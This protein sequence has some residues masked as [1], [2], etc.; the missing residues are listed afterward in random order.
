MRASG[1]ATGSWVMRNVAA[2]FLHLLD[3]GQSPQDLA[4]AYVAVRREIEA[5]GHGLEHKYEVLVLNKSDLMSPGDTERKRRAVA[6]VSGVSAMMMSGEQGDNVENVLRALAAALAQWRSEH[7]PTVVADTEAVRAQERIAR[8]RKGFRPSGAGRRER[9]AHLRSYPRRQNRFFN[10]G[11]CGVGCAGARLAFRVR[12]RRGAGESARAG[13]RARVVGRDC[14]WA[15]ARFELG[16]GALKLEEAQAAAAVGQI[17][18]AR[19]WSEALA[20]HQADGRAGVADLGRYG[21]PAA[22][23]QRAVDAQDVDRVG[24]RAG[25]QRERHGG[26]GRDPL[27]RQ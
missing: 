10:S 7:P 3:G 6:E 1:S 23:S 13:R 25:D 11:G 15:G 19:A 21:E 2:F 27:R 26:D 20:A 9:Q 16:A 22:L 8:S 5:Y 14:A 17:A 4:K 12:G 18:L 24:Q